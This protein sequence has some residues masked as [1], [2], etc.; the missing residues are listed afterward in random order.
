MSPTFIKLPT[1]SDGSRTVLINLNTVTDIIPSLWTSKEVTHECSI[2]S[3]TDS[4]EFFQVFIPYPE[5]VEI[6][7]RHCKVLHP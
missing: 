6:I 3:V 2:V 1:T 5:L 4:S 7:S